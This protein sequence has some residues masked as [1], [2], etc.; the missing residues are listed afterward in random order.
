MFW[1]INERKLPWDSVYKIIQQRINKTDKTDLEVSQI[2]RQKLV[3]ERTKN[4][5]EFIDEIIRVKHHQ[6]GLAF[7]QC[8]SILKRMQM[9]QD[10]FLLC[11]DLEDYKVRIDWDRIRQNRDLDYSSLLQLKEKP[12]Q[13]D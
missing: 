3:Y 4:D 11:F 9:R 8:F 5:D 7:K 1:C 13:L 12:F 2:Q 6:A 10:K